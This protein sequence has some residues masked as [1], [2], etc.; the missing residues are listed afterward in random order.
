MLIS[1]LAGNDWFFI[2][3]TD[4]GSKYTNIVDFKKVLTIIS[5]EFSSNNIEYA[6]IGGFALGVRGVVRATVDIDLLVKGDDIDQADHILKGYGFQCIYKTENVSQ[7]ISDI[8][9]L[10]AIDILHAFRP[11][12]LEMLN[13]SEDI[14]LFD[15]ELTVPVLKPED[16]IGLK[17][18]AIANNPDRKSIDMPDIENLLQ[19]H[20]ENINWP[21]LKEYFHLFTMDDQFEKLQKKYQ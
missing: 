15:G 7:Y 12:S 21:K 2:L 20:K 10:G 14:Q 3:S 6:L 19:F 18:Q 13:N 9:P 16:I 4:W 5:K 17:I 1:Y 11:I 8:K